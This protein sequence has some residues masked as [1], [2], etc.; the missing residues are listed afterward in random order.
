MSDTQRAK[1]EQV[2]REVLG[3]AHVDRSTADPA[4]FNAPLI[5]YVTKYA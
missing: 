2:R 5:E 3:D 4:A 1:G